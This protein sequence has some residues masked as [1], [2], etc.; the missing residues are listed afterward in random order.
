MDE[1][2][3]MSKPRV[4]VIGAGASGLAAVKQCLEEGLEVVC[5]DQEPAVGGLWRYVPKNAA[6]EDV[7]SSLY[8]STII[9]TSKEMMAYSDFPPPADWPTFLPHRHVV[10]YL[11]MYCDHFNLRPHIKFNRKVISISPESGPNGHTGRWEIVTQR[12]QRKAANAHATPTERSRSN[13]RNKSRVRTALSPVP[14]SRLSGAENESN[15]RVPRGVDGRRALSPDRDFSRSRSR[16]PSPRRALS[17]SRN[18]RGRSPSLTPRSESPFPS[19]D[20]QAIYEPIPI[21]SSLTPTESDI[22]SPPPSPSSSDSSSARIKRNKAHRSRSRAPATT[23]KQKCETFTHLIVAT[24]HHWK[25]RL[26]NFTNSNMFKGQFLHSHSYRV[27]YPFKDLRVLIVGIGNSGADIATELSHHAKSVILSARTSTWILPRFSV[28]G[29]PIDHLSSRITSLLPKNITSFVFE[30]LLR[31]Q[32]GSLSQYGIKPEHRILESHPT[33]NGG[34]LE[35]IAAGKVIMK[36]NIREFSRDGQSVKFDD[37]TEEKVDVV[38]YCTGYDISYPFLRDELEILGQEHEG[39][40]VRLWK[41]IFPWGRENIAFV[42]L[43]QPIGSILPVSEMQSR[44]ISCVFAGHIGLPPPTEM[45]DAIDVEHRVRSQRFVKSERHTIEVEYVPYMDE[46]AKTVG[47]EV[48][49]WSLLKKGE[50]S[51]LRGVLFGPAIAAQWRLFGRG[52][53]EGA[54]NLIAGLGRENGIEGSDS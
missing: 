37:E 33:I 39:G 14:L 51:V 53:W 32:H 28:F 31:L 26:P 8:A 43:V 15:G 24:G 18:R 10:K 13:A 1:V 21:P 40:R 22:I 20:P 38:I 30:N 9:N 25:P 7:H 27:P 36:P 11:N 3:G 45:R 5:F 2:L 4:A 41:H 29:K 48:D 16:A 23:V 50:W 19:Y 52:A 44:L 6:D 42:G 34:V 47:C 17:P 54:K 49:V 46:L 35:R 12:V